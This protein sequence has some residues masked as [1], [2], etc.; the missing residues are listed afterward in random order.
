MSC[1]AVTCS[2]PR[3]V[4]EYLSGGSETPVQRG[5]TT[6][7]ETRDVPVCKGKA[8][9]SHASWSCHPSRTF[10]LSL[11]SIPR[12]GVLYCSA[13]SPTFTSPGPDA[14]AT[15]CGTAL[16]YRV[17]HLREYRPRFKGQTEG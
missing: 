13:A 6:R 9:L 3:R 14:V 16:M 8:Q 10:P 1:R 15:L 17:D 12:R 7:L 2:N 4:Q 5:R 11:C